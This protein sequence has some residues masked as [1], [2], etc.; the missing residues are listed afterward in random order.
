MKS[1]AAGAAAGAAA[2]MT[3]REQ[4]HFINNNRTG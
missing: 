3:E 2:H 4:T 1:A